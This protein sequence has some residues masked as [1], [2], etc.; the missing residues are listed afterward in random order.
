MFWH[1]LSHYVKTKVP[2][3]S[4]KADEAHINFCFPRFRVFLSL[5]KQFAYT[6]KIGS[7]FAD[8]LGSY[9]FEAVGIGYWYYETNMMLNYGNVITWAYNHIF[10]L[11]KV[12]AAVNFKAILGISF[13]NISITFIYWTIVISIPCWTNKMMSWNTKHSTVHSSPK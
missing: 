4:S 7:A 11:T 3:L 6:F 12:I 8:G 10:H 2:T 9:F 5:A 1:Q 13:R